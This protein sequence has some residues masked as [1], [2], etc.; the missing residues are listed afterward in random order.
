MLKKEYEIR[1]SMDK[2]ERD[3]KRLLYRVQNYSLTEFFHERYEIS[4]QV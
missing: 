4:D 1:D 3:M 2:F